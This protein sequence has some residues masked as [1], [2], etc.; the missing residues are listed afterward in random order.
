MRIFV[1]TGAGVSAE[2]GLSTFRD[3]SGVWTRYDFREVA[4]PEGFARDPAKVHAFYNLRRANLKTVEPNAAHRALARLQAELTARGGELYLCT[5]NVDDLH[6]RGGASE[7]VHMHGDLSK[8]RCEDCDAAFTWGEDLSTETPCPACGGRGG[9]RPDVV[10]FGEIP[11]RMDEIYEALARADRFVSIGT[12]GSVWP[13]AGFAQDARRAGV[14]TVEINLEP[15]ETA[16]LFQ[17]RLYGPATEQ[18]PAWVER[19]LG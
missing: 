3:P 8:V 11:R 1:L 18:V 12:S 14:P 17:V 19:V 6:E 10:W 15:S 4:T 13:A 16:G 2:S 7:V 9:L 5:Q